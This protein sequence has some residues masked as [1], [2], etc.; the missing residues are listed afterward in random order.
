[1]FLAV[2][3]AISS[4]IGAFRPAMV[5]HFG[6]CNLG[7]RT[8]CWRDAPAATERSAFGPKESMLRVKERLKLILPLTLVLIFGLLFINTKPAF[9]ASVVVLAVP[10]SAVADRAD[11]G[12]RRDGRILG[13]VARRVSA[14]GAAQQRARSGRSG[15]ARRREARTPEGDDG[16]R[17]HAR[18]VAHHVATGTGA[19]LMKRIAASMVGGLLTSFAME[20]L[21]YPAI[22]FLWR[23]RQLPAAS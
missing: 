22:Y 8:A 1:V 6:R 21:M 18:P 12:G 13:L 9:K 7:V 2:S 4:L 15:G 17:G 23:N 16:V 20:L 11:G 5:L 10:F 3:N 14:R 19:D